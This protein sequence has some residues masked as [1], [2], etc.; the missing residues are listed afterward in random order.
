MTNSLF[1]RIR[2]WLGI[3]DLRFINL[4]LGH[5]YIYDF[6]WLDGK[7]RC[8][9]WLLISLWVSSFWKYCS[10]LS[11]P[12]VQYFDFFPVYCVSTSVRIYWYNRRY[13]HSIWPLIDFHVWDP[14]CSI[15]WS[16]QLERFLFKMMFGF[17]FFVI[18]FCGLDNVDWSNFGGLCATFISMALIISL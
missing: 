9:F 5:I 17:S 18:S 4:I 7:F 13:N 6:P 2:S 11:I 8:V 16:S 15:L 3:I 14:L 12:S 1:Y 10:V